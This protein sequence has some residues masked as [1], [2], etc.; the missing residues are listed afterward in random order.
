MNKIDHSVNIAWQKPQLSN[1]P[2]GYQSST[3]GDLIYENIFELTFEYLVGTK[4]AGEI[5]EFGSFRGYTAKVIVKNMLK[6]NLNGSFHLF[7]SFKGLPDIN[8]SEDYDSYEVAQNKSWFEGQMAVDQ[9][10][11]VALGEA[12]SETIG[13]SKY[14][15]YEGFF[16]ETLPKFSSKFKAA[17]CHIDCDLYSSTI[18]VLN[19]LFSNNMLVDG[20]VLMFDD[21]NCNRGNPNMGQRRALSEILNNYKKVKVS[22]FHSYGWHGQSF[23]YHSPYI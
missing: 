8:N 14:E 7:D 18:T 3:R 21:W 5:F 4:V 22:P 9:S 19:Y 23:V 6:F 12:L 15:I 10:V 16:D 11:P 1:K 20:A 13:K 17:L 2:V